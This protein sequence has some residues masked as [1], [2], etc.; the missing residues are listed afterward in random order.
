MHMHMHVHIHM[1]MQC[2]MHRGDVD[3][4]DA[5]FQRAVQGW[6]RDQGIQFAYACF[7]QLQVKDMTAAEVMYSKVLQVQNVS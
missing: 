7:L 6:P 3:A 5:F 2:N 1:H 4:A